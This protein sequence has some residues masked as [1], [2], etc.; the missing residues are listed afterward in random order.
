MRQAWL[1]DII[2]VMNVEEIRKNFEKDIERYGLNSKKVSYASIIIEELLFLYAP[3]SQ[4]ADVSIKKTATQL[5]AVISIPGENRT[6]RSMEEE[7]NTYLLDSTVNNTGFTLKHSYENNRNV[8]TLTLENYFSVINNVRFAFRFLEEDKA[9]LILGCVF[10]LVAIMANLAIPYFTGTLVTSYTDNNFQQVV[11]SV[12]ALLG[13][14]IIYYI[15]IA[16]AG[17]NYNKVSINLFGLLQTKLLEKLF[18]VKDE[19]LE[20]YGSAQYIQRINTDA[21]VISEDVAGAFNI[22]SNA[23]YY[24][25]VLIASL[26]FDKVIFFA[27]LFTFAGLYIMENRRLARMDTNRRRLMEREE[28]H[29]ELIQELVEGACE[30]KL[31]GSK[32]Y[33]I[34]KTAE[35]A[36]KTAD[37]KMISVLD[38]TKMRTANN[39]YIHICFFFIMLYLGFALHKSMMSL[40]TALVLFNY[41]TIISMPLVALI[42]QYM[43]FKKRFSISC[44]RANGLLYGNEFAKEMSGDICPY[45]LEGD[46]EFDNVS[47]TYNVPGQNRNKVL[48]NISLRIKAGST[49]AFVGKSGAGKSTILKLIAG[50]R[51]ANIG[52]ITIDGIDIQKMDKD[53]LR[54]NIA[55]VSQDAFLFNTSIKENLLMAKPD[56]TM[57]EL[58]DVCRKACILDDIN[59]TEHGFDTLLNEK[60]V[61]FSGGQ[62]QRLVIA[63]SLL[64]GTNILILDEATSAVDNITQQKIM[65]TIKNLEGECTIII[66][67]HRLST[68]INCDK[69]FL[70]S[71]GHVAAEGTHSEMIENCS[72]YRDLYAAE[73]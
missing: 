51:D 57:E 55:V 53:A 17:I 41:F 4:E 62:K 69:V 44:E 42:Q 38:D 35:S 63:R 2:Q 60:G 68:I 27:E 61:R 14:R 1:Y 36:G 39:L 26:T 16:L 30:I 20:A 23:V 58:E 43:D 72:A 54:R 64:K 50:Q 73:A 5:S 46:I 56:A 47:F 11:W 71:D 19:K 65:Q 18:G 9:T 52:T 49:T 28:Q 22:V 40:S 7:C 25:G 67:A 66:V 37:I 10:N 24:A 12:S 8:I 21:A 29:A 59:E 48:D 45:L 33:L 31:L 32:K 70:I 3:D 13:A 15:F 34:G 6:P